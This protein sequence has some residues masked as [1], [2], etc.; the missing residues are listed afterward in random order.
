MDNQLVA[1]LD[2]EGG[3][4]ISKLFATNLDAAILHHAAGFALGC[5]RLDVHEQVKSAISSGFD[6]A[7]GCIARDCVTAVDFAFLGSSGFGSF[8]TVVLRHDVDGEAVL[9]IVRVHLA[10]GDVSHHLL[11]FFK[12]DVRQKFEPVL[13]DAIGEAVNLVVH[14][15]GGFVQ[16]NVVADGLTHLDLAV[17]T[18]EN[19]HKEADLRFHAFKKLEI[20]ATEHVELLVCAAEFHVALDGDGIIALHHRVHEFVQADRRIG[21][22]AVVEVFAFEHLGDSELAHEFSHLAER[23]LGKPFAVVMNFHLVATDDLEELLLIFLG[24]LE[25][26]FVRKARTGLVATARVTNLCGVVTTMR[27]TV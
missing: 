18:E 5:K 13:D 25:H 7:F 1:T 14:H 15:V 6:G 11:D 2:F 20:A 27:T 9:G 24:I 4:R 19:R 21:G 17:G 12:R 23:E 22:I 8:G 26:L 3:L 10:R 16:A